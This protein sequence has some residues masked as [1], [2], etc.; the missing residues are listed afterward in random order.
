MQA[1]GVSL[2]ALNCLQFDLSTAQGKLFAQPMSALAEFEPDVLRERVRSG[3]NAA[4]ACR[5]TIGRQKVFA[6]TQRRMGPLILSRRDEGKS[7]RKIAHELQI[8]TGTVHK[9]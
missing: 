8:S 2:I 1:R 5:V 7:I 4:K 9:V 6:S 3:I